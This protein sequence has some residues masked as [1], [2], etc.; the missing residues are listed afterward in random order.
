M[1]RDDMITVVGNGCMYP[2][3]QGRCSKVR[4]W[5]KFVLDV[6]TLKIEGRCS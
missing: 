4:M 1:Q 3:K 5:V 6:D 2:L